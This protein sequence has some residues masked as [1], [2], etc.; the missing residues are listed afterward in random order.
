M[1][2]AADSVDLNDSIWDSKFDESEP[3]F[4][5]ASSHHTESYL[6]SQRK[7]R[8]DQRWSNWQQLPPDYFNVIWTS[9]HTWLAETQILV[10]KLGLI[11]SWIWVYYIQK[12]E[13]KKETL[14]QTQK[15]HSGCFRPKNSPYSKWT[16]WAI[17]QKL[18]L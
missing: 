7:G 9:G 18:E 8:E 13:K 16:R 10:T 5:R 11:P 15:I 12:K 1:C 17:L 3:I 2:P 6:S 14:N 4:F